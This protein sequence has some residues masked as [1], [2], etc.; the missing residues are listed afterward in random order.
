MSC[1]C[2]KCRL[3]AIASAHLAEKPGDARHLMVLAASLGRLVGVTLAGLPA[4]H[5][6]VFGTTL[7]LN[8]AAALSQLE[9]RDAAIRA[10]EADE[11]AST[12]EAG[13]A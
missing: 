7:G 11:F 1:D 2:L 4:E 6:E 13:H 5:R 10:G 8:A 9:A 12:H 3:V